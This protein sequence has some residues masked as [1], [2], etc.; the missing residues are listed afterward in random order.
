MGNLL[1]TGRVTGNIGVGVNLMM[2]L[3]SLLVRIS[4][5]SQANAA[6]RKRN[7]G[8]GLSKASQEHSG[9]RADQKG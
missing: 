9:W 4:V 7:L 1:A 3:R 8:Y 5:T 2:I 6:E